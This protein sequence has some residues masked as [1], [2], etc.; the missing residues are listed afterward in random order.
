MVI[1]RLGRLHVLLNGALL[2]ILIGGALSGPDVEPSNSACPKA[3]EAFIKSLETIVFIERGCDCLIEEGSKALEAGVRVDGVFDF[4][5]RLHLPFVRSD[6]G[7]VE[8]LAHVC[9]NFLKEAR[10]LECFFVQAGSGFRADSADNWAGP[11]CCIVLLSL[12]HVLIVCP[13]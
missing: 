4:V 8:H 2:H 1:K 10:V 9:S 3:H 11:D 7:H 5:T 12:H 13:G 6:L